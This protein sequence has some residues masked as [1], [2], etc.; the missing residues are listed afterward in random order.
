[1]WF[2]NPR[3]D[4]VVRVATRLSW[5]WAFLW[6]PVYY[7]IKGIWLHA[8]ASLV[9]GWGLGVVAFWPAALVVGLVYAV[10]NTEIVRKYYND[11]GWVY[12]S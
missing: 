2:R 12:I 1:M 10:K 4:T 9:L 6:A 11:R 7:A 8:A 3:T 5:L